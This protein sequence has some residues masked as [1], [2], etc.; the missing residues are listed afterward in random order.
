[1][2]NPI[3]KGRGGRGGKGMEGRG[4]EGKRR[5][6]KGGEGKGKKGRKNSL[7]IAKFNPLHHQTIVFTIRSLSITQRTLL[8]GFRLTFCALMGA[9]PFSKANR[10]YE[11]RVSGFK[12]KC[13]LSVWCGTFL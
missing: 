5:K 4:R 13:F 12:D 11:L 7:P 3:R 9:C 1:M 2:M 10:W 6:A 8:I